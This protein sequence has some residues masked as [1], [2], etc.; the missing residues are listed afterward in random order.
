MRKYDELYM[1][2]KNDRKKSA[3]Q[4]KKESGRGV[5][6]QFDDKGKKRPHK[7]IDVFDDDSDEEDDNYSS[8]LAPELV[9][10]EVKVE[11][12]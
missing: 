11:A 3:P 9:Y 5:K 10:D 6:K 12:V 8:H 4:R 7:C 1:A 2:I